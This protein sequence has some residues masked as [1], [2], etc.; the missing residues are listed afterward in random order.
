MLF[1]LHRF[2]LGLPSR[3]LPFPSGSPAEDQGCGPGKL[4]RS[5]A[6]QEAY[7]TECPQFDLGAEGGVEFYGQ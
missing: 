2:T 5:S 6:A 4:P 3:G 7:T 1:F